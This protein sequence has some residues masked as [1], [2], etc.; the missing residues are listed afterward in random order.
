MKEK[1]K[2][3]LSI[4]LSIIIFTFYNV[5]NDKKY[6]FEATTFIKPILSDE[7]LEYNL[8]NEIYN[9]ILIENKITKSESKIQT[10][11]PIFDNNQNSDT[12]NSNTPVLRFKERHSN[13]NL[14]IN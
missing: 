13:K 12:E 9:E 4:F 3:I 5:T 2:I 1:Y 6:D 14:S 7:I 10:I 11:N 8:L